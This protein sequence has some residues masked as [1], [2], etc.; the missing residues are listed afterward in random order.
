MVRCTG[1]VS[2]AGA[3]AEASPRLSSWSNRGRGLRV[4]PTEGDTRAREPERKGTEQTGEGLAREAGGG[5][6]S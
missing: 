1:L 5:P 6:G 3:V 2:G 4:G